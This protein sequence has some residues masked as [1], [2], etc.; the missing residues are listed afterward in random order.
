MKNIPLFRSCFFLFLFVISSNALPMMRR[1]DPFDREDKSVSP[2]QDK[3][4]R[5]LTNSSNDTSGSEA[6][7]TDGKLPA[8][9]DD[10][11]FG[12]FHTVSS[13]ET[14]RLTQSNHNKNRPLSCLDP[15]GIEDNNVKIGKALSEAESELLPRLAEEYDAVKG[16]KRFSVVTFLGQH[17]FQ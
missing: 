11:E 9:N 1:P 3:R 5:E 6:R 15:D 10:N 8:E 2:E 4:T 14:S 17:L 13:A 12:I 16:E 7:R